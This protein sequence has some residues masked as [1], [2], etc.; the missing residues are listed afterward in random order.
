MNEL[1][2]TTSLPPDAFLTSLQG[3]VTPQPDLRLIS[4]LSPGG[5]V[6]RGI[7]PPENC[8]THFFGIVQKDQFSI[9]EHT[10]KRFVSP[11]QPI[12]QGKIKDST[13]TISPKMHSQAYPLL[14]LYTVF[15]ILLM[16]LGILVM[17]EDFF[18]FILTFIFGLSLIAFP[19]YRTKNHFE[20]CLHTAIASWE[21]L[22]LQLHRKDQT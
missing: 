21:A 6:V 15:G 13:I 20:T 19:R 3:H 7:S 11:Y 16:L 9:V 4:Y 14:W 18:I 17:Q 22:P 12:L 10:H 2:Y 1:I 8:D 5:V